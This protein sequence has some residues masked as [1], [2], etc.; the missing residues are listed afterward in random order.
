MNPYQMFGCLAFVSI[1]PLY[2]YVNVLPP[3]SFVFFHVSVSVK[4]LVRMDFSLNPH[5]MLQLRNHLASK[6]QQVSGHNRDE[7][8]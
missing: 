2:L 6:Q 5:F 7:G 8:V 1:D 4:T 3:A